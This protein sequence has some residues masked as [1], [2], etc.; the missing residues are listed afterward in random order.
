MQLHVLAGKGYTRKLPLST[1]DEELLAS[2]AS[3]GIHQFLK[4]VF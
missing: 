4:V 3:M 2:Y 1:W